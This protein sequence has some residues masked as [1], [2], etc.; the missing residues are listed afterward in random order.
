MSA[1]SLARQCQAA[2]IIQT[3]WRHAA[4]LKPP[5]TGGSAGAPT[6]VWTES[7]PGRGS[8]VAQGPAF[9]PR[10]R[11]GPRRGAAQGACVHL[12]VGVHVLTRARGCV[13]TSVYMCTWLHVCTAAYVGPC[14]H[15]CTSASMC[16]SVHMST[17]VHVYI[18]TCVPT[19]S[20]RYPLLL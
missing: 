13:C 9:S 14:G 11:R 2:R 5:G 8:P 17:S 6:P 3:A 4:A 20:H 15:L 12:R 1:D 7:R 18:C 10:R 16:T 19:H